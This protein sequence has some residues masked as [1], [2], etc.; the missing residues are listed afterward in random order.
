[1]S[2]TLSPEP[3]NLDW[4]FCWWKQAS[5]QPES[6]DYLVTLLRRS[7]QA[8]AWE[9]ENRVNFSIIY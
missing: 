4:K 2:F 8:P 3:M 5:P 1:M 9:L 7:E 6:L